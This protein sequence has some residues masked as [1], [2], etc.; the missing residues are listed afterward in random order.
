MAEPW[1]AAAGAYGAAGVALAAS[2]HLAGSDAH[3]A[4]LI[5]LA[6]RFVILHA[7]ALAAVGGLARHRPALPLTLAGAGFAS[8]ALLF[9][10]GLTLLAAT[11]S[12]IGLWS[13][14]IGGSTLILG[15]LAL[16]W[17]GISSRPEPR[18]RPESRP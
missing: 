5:D 16:F 3:A 13:T 18:A 14:P 1:I 11:A 7:L 15:W 10:G 6:A 4:M 8:G 2:T 9:G 12:P 17:Y